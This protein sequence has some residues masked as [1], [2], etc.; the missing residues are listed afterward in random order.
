MKNPNVMTFET[1]SYIRSLLEKDLYELDD[2]YRETLYMMGDGK[3]VIPAKEVAH[4]NFSERHKRLK[5]MMEQL[6][7][8]A[9][10]SN[11]PDMD[12]ETNKFWGLE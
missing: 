2:L 9:G 6:H 4:R 8:A 1:Y 3:K 11:G 7:Y 12:D 5:D 10:M